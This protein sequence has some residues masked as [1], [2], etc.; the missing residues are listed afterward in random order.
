MVS[1]GDRV[2]PTAGAVSVVEVR[3]DPVEGDTYVLVQAV[4]AYSGED[5]DVAGRAAAGRYPF[6]TPIAY[7]VPADPA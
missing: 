3:E 2:R 5:E 4:E 7:L 1:K 6:R